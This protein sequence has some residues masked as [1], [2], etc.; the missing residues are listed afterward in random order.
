MFHQE[1]TSGILLCFFLENPF[2]KKKD[3]ITA[4]DAG[5]LHRYPNKKADRTILGR[6]WKQLPTS[7]LVMVVLSAQTDHK[8]TCLCHVD[9]YRAEKERIEYTPHVDAFPYVCVCLCLCFCLVD[10]MRH[11]G[12]ICA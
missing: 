11:H 8:K 12:E 7:S 2:N 3:S 1:N 6:K 9:E 10:T 4:N 5:I